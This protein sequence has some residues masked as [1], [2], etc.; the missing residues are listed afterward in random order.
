MSSARKRQK[1][2]RVA[3]MLDHA[4][5]KEMSASHYANVMKAIGE[6][7][8]RRHD[9]MRAA[10]VRYLA[11]NDTEGFGCACEPNHTCG[12]CS[13]HKRQQV[14]RDALGSNVPHEGAA[15][16]LSRTL[17]LDVVVGGDGGNYGSV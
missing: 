9:V 3:T 13:A 6:E 12:P 4:K 17:P 1:A 7:S 5:Q 15:A 14:L 10:I 2:S 8:A 16:A 11:E